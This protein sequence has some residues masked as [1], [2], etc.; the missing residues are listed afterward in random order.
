M[1][2]L[3]G[4]LRYSIDLRTVYLKNLSG[5]LNDEGEFSIR[6]KEKCIQLPNSGKIGPILA[7]TPCF[8]WGL[9][10]VLIKYL[11]LKDKIALKTK[12]C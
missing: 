11:S 9:K 7:K 10:I 3:I 8:Y 1:K 5:I 6:K 4:R 12:E 2:G